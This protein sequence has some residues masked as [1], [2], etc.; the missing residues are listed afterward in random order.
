MVASN[1]SPMLV[2]SLRP[3]HLSDVTGGQKSMLFNAAP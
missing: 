1:G 3:S 2:N